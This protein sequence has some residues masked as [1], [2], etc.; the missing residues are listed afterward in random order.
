M[1][2]R[3]RKTVRIE[4][5]PLQREC[6]RCDKPMRRDYRNSRTIYSPRSTVFLTLQILRCKTPDCSR[7]RTPYRPEVEWHYALPGTKFAL[8]TCAEIY[9]AHFVGALNRNIHKFL[10]AYGIPSALRSISN[11]IRRY[12]QLFVKAAPLSWSPSHVGRLNEERGAILDI[13]VVYLRDPYLTIIVRECLSNLILASVA[14]SMEKADE[15]LRPFFNS[16]AELLP[17]PTLKIYCSPH[18]IVRREAAR[19]WPNVRLVEVSPDGV[20]GKRTDQ[21]DVRRT[22]W[23]N[24]P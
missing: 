11:V 8:D 12:D 4:L 17:V 23:R 19:V 9:A 14:T 20:V 13:V 5:E 3:S 15:E 2:K 18:E 1:A 6:P 22:A 24:R 16:I 10:G 21:R 7:Y